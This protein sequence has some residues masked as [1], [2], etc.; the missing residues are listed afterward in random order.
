MS[1]ETVLPCTCNL[2]QFSGLPVLFLLMVTWPLQAGWAEPPAPT[3]K[4]QA[5]LI[6]LVRQDCGSCHGL[7]LQGGLGPA[8]LPADLSGKDFA[9][10]RDTILEGR[11]GTPMPPWKAF[12]SRDETQW[13]VK[14]LQMGF[15]DEA[16]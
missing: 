8:L 2:N 3:A 12:L 10:L 16:R 9:M 15:P 4:R 13:M 11:S 14:Q 5:E 7:T 6:H 1:T